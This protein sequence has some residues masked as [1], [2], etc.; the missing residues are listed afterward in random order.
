LH[1]LRPLRVFVQVDD[2]GLTSSRQQLVFVQ[3]DDFAKATREAAV[4]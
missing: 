2:R 1:A 4:R 3:V